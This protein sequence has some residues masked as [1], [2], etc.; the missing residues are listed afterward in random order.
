MVR[1]LL[2]DDSEDA[3]LD[4]LIGIEILLTDNEKSEVTYKL[5]IRVAYIMSKLNKGNNVD[6]RIII[7]ELYKYRSFIVHGSSDKNKFSISK[8]LNKD[9]HSI[10]LDIFKQTL[11]FIILKKELL[12][13][14][15][16]PQDA[17]NMIMNEF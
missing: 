11:K 1:S 13:S 12:N 6:Y 17:D 16:I 3:F 15:N 5:S 2:R 14:K 8:T 9:C 7:K 10:A 4:I